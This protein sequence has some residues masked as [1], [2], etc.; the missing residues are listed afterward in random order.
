[1]TVPLNGAPAT[2]PADD[3]KNLDGVW[4]VVLQPM[5]GE[6]VYDHLKLTQK[7]NIITGSF[8]DNEH[9]NKQYPVA[10]SIDGKTVHI[11]VTKDDGSTIR[12]NGTVDNLTD[13]IGLVQVGSASI[14]FTAA[15]RPKYKFIDTIAPMPGGGGLGTGNGNG[16]P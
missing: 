9:G 14:A 8:M 3:R 6:P 11:V 5:N 4:E 10:G 12:F 15:Y 7:V 13:M 1:V 2:S 16:R